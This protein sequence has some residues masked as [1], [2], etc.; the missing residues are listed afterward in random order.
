MSRQGLRTYES[1]CA[2]GVREIY[3]ELLRVPC[4][5][6]SV[7]RGVVSR[8]CGHDDLLEIA[9]KSAFAKLALRSR[10][11]S[12][13]RTEELLESAARLRVSA[14]YRSNDTGGN[15]RGSQKLS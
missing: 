8:E 11:A 10:S 5:P 2:A 1:F 12:L 4:P 14:L 6:G 3:H 7:K 9:V 15:G 13:L